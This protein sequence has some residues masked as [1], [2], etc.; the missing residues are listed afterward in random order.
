MKLDLKI[1]ECMTVGVL[2]L[3]TSSTAKQAAQL[4]RKS[5]VGSI[6]VTD[7]GKA[8]G[9]LTERDIVYSIV[10]D[11]KDASKTTLK[12]IMSKPLKVIGAHQSI[13]DAALALKENKVKRLPVVDKKGQLVGIVSEGDLIRVY[14]GIVD[15]VSESNE[16]GPYQREKHTYTGICETCGLYSDELKMS[17]GHLYCDECREED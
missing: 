17:N 6:I 1:G 4:L 15:V 16:L 13:E 8:V 7:K 9:I 12:S 10:A 2:T 3:Q 14:P 5:R 11:G